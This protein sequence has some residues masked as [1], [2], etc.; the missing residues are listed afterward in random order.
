MDI[1]ELPGGGLQGYSAVLDLYLRWE[2]GV[3][4]WYDPATGKHI[5]TF[6]DERAR[7]DS[8]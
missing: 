4:G 6:E 7:A 8:E 1:E 2:E 3:L 5:T